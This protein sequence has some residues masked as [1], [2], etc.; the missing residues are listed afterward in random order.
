MC[1]LRSLQV[2]RSPFSGTLQPGCHGGKLHFVKPELVARAKI[3]EWT[4][5]GKL[6]QASYKGFRDDKDP[7]ELSK[8]AERPGGLA[9]RFPAR[10]PA[11]A[12]PK[13]V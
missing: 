1:K 2:A 10:W 7:T 9:E 8:K 6:R 12:Q 3:A 13:M 11:A 5:G 4:A